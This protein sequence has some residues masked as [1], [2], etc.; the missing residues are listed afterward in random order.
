MRVLS[1]LLVVACT[2]AASLCSGQIINGNFESGNVGFTSDYSHRVFSGSNL[3]EGSYAIVTNPRDVHLSWAIYG[4]HTTGSGNFLVANGAV[5]GGDTVVWRQTVP[6]TSGG[7]KC[8]E[9][10]A[11]STFP[12]APSRLFLR[13]N[14]QDGPSMQ[15]SSTVGRWSKYACEMQVL[16]GPLTLEIINANSIVFGN[17]FAIDDISMPTCPPDSRCSLPYNRTFENGNTDFTSLYDYRVIIGGQMRESSY[18]VE[19]SP[20]N[21][22]TS[23]ANY[24]DHTTGFGKMLVANGS[25]D[26]TKYVWSQS[27]P[28]TF[29]SLYRF[30][31]WGSSPFG[32]SPSRLVLSVNGVDVPTVF[33]MPSQVGFWQ[34]YQADFRVAARG[35]SVLRIRDLRSEILG[36]D[37]AIDDL[38]VRLLPPEQ[39]PEAEIPEP[40]SAPSLSERLQASMLRLGASTSGDCRCP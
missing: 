4:D 12:V 1:A 35:N 17:D 30:E 20:R 21:V 36:N 9:F 22:H 19:T 24:G 16:P 11:S 40:P 31:L 39:D 28:L 2:L 5:N 13:V 3:S 15:L 38:C 10:W 18:S 32:M 34:V 7:R 23:W 26:T 37:F 33:Q 29:G 25:P 8:F 6:F 14:G 27:L